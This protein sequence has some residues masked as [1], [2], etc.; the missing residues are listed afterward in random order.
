MF[1]SPLT[2]NGY[3]IVAEHIGDLRYPQDLEAAHNG[4]DR[5][6][7]SKYFGAGPAK[8][9]LSEPYNIAE[10][11]VT[12]NNLNTLRGMHFQNPG[13]PKLIQCITGSV[14]G[15]LLCVDPELPEFGRSINFVLSE[16]GGRILVPGNWALGYR[17]ISHEASRILYLAG[18]DFVPG[19]DG[20]VD[21]FD[22]ELDLF[23]GYKD[24]TDQRFTAA[25]ATLSQKDVDLPSFDQ[26][27]QTLTR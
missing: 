14:L 12:T 20:G 5:G 4:D 24:G 16:G 3:E 18:A 27:A 11:F 7:H 10:V 13:Q 23:W 9:A 8:I 25:D 15:N 22:A 6:V 2:N 21:P 1:N 26:Y 17:S 19:G